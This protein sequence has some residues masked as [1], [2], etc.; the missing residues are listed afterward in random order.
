MHQIHIKK[1]KSSNWGQPKKDYDLN[2][3]AILPTWKNVIHYIWNRNKIAIVFSL[4]QNNRSVHLLRYE[5][6]GTLS[7]YEHSFTKSLLNEFFLRF[8][9]S[10]NERTQRVRMF[11]MMPASPTVKRKTPL[12]QKSNQGM[13]LSASSNLS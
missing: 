7:I 13:N 5:K 4:H 8:S 6:Y 10:P 3:R 2:K 9:S 11:P 12:T 1:K